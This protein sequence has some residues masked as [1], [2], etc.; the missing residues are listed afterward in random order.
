M[1]VS[2]PVLRILQIA[3]R[4]PFPLHDGGSLAV[5]AMMDLQE[6]IPSSIRLFAPNASRNHIS[7]QNLPE[8]FSQQ[9]RLRTFDLNT[10]LAPFSM[11]ANWLCSHEPYH[12]IRF[13][14]P[15]VWNE[16]RRL[17]MEET[18]DIIQ[19]EGPFLGGWLP[20]M[21]EYS[22]ATIVLRAHNVEH[23]IWSELA[24]R[25]K[26]PLKKAYLSSQSSRLAAFELRLAQSVDGI[27]AISQATAQF[28]AA[29]TPKPVEVLGSVVTTRPKPDPI[30][31]ERLKQLSFLGS[32]DWQPNREAVHH[33][34][35][36][37]WPELHRKCPDMQLNIAGKNFPDALMRKKIDGV[38]MH[39]TVADAES[40]LKSHPVVVVPLR[41]GSGIRIKILEALA[42]GLPIISSA[43][44]VQGLD[45]E[46][47][48]HYLA[49]EN[50]EEF[51]QQC[52]RLREHPQLASRL[53]EAGH[54]FVSSHFGATVLAPK[55]S[56]FYR[57]LRSL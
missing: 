27:L 46:A 8:R 34:L 35:E 18:F 37:W 9:Y 25:T 11:A 19:L 30:P 7:V 10:A 36:S 33:L 53:G 16:L 45:V 42:L 32:L 57:H 12:S 39:G 56:D 3:N 41:S 31:P 38:L 28:F 24:T 23:E 49:A 26:N 17:L 29:N 52:Q 4:I 48:V 21:R 15:I 51:A 54:H 22:D 2:L 55:L 13:M 6:K 20:M 47:D 40:F 50:A 5:Q 1:S 43:K 44:G 14:Q